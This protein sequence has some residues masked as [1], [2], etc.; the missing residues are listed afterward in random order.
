MNAMLNGKRHFLAVLA[1][2]SVIGSS[3]ASAAD[4]AWLGGIGAVYFDNYASESTNN[5]TV[6]RNNFTSNYVPWQQLLFPGEN[7]RVIFN[8]DAA[9]GGTNQN[10]I[11]DLRNLGTLDAQQTWYLGG[12]TIGNRGEILLGGSTEGM[13][14]PGLFADHNDDHIVNELDYRLWRSNYGNTVGSGGASASVSAVPEPS[15]LM[16]IGLLFSFASLRRRAR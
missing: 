14:G 9:A 13:T 1:L 10:G 5:G 4:F 8:A 7:D 15:S 6:Y 12:T 11:G 2:S 3:L 16:L